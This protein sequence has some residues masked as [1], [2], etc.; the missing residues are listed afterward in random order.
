M[1]QIQ[2]NFEKFHRQNPYVY[3]LFDRFTR[4]MI[5]VGL[6][7]GSA[8]LV[9]ERI[10]WETAVE[11]VTEQPVKLNNN[12]KA[13]YARMWMNDHPEYPNYFRTRVLAI[14]SVD[15]VNIPEKE[16]DA[17]DPNGYF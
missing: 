4:R 2:K 7:N 1:D 9:T 10:R 11:T 16:Y 12:Y 5:N 13:R 14:D 8:A 15:S 6:K 17:G 3:V